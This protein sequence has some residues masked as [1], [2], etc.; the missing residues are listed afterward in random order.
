MYSLKTKRGDK[1]VLRP[2]G[3]APL[4][5]AYL[6]HG[7]HTKPQPVMFYYNG[8]F[9][10]HEQPQK[11]RRREFKQF[12]LEIL[13]SDDSI[14]DALVI[15]ASVVILEEAAG[16]K[17]IAVHLNSL[18]CKDCRR[19]YKKKL[20]AHYRKKLKTLCPNC[21]RRIKTNPLRLLDCKDEKCAEVKK[22]APQIINFLCQGCTSHFKKL[23]EILDAVEI[24]YYLDHYLVR[25]LDYYT[26]TVFELRLED[27]DLEFG[28][29]GRYDD[30]AKI[31]ANKIVPAVGVAMGV[32]R[33]MLE[34]PENKKQ[35]NAPK[36]PKIF[37]IQ[38]GV[39]A[40]QRSLAI[41]EQL[42]KAKISV[43]HSL[44][45]DNLKS[46]LKLANKLKAPYALIFGQKESLDNTIM[47]RDMDTASQE[48]IPL[49]KLIDYLKKRMK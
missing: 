8:S 42:R 21:Q 10:R 49:S 31:L 2:E 48:T 19:L 6:E 11:G 37:F 4:M 41:I 29:G 43:K 14:T 25:G 40:K 17:P 24:T 16:L 28:G 46:Q 15:K 32:D 26:R 30:L 36:P 20:A 1:L 22:E 38:L 27:S 13:G 9:F 5:R 44:S 35:G 33:I 39:E 23:L 7:L 45:K 3:T 18:G 34:I 47:L 12:G